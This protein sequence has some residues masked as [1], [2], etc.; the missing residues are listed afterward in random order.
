MHNPNTQGLE[1]GRPDIRGHSLYRESLRSTWDVWYP[2]LARTY[3]TTH[4]CLKILKASHQ[5]LV[6]VSP[7]TVPL[8]HRVTEAACSEF[9]MS[10][11]LV[12][13]I[14]GT[15]ANIIIFLQNIFAVL[16]RGKDLLN[17][18]VVFFS[19]PGVA[20]VSTVP[21][22]ARSLPAMAC[23]GDTTSVYRLIQLFKSH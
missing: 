19:S 2:M 9:S 21:P 18:D 14:F 17:G 12:C 15:K 8:T 6:N 10:Y 20:P 3:I 5:P 16:K 1:V 13:H 22:F 7:S 4:I 23:E 11:R